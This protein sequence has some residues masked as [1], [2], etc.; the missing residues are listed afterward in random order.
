MKNNL[1]L[2]CASLLLA[3]P[4][5]H[6][7]N[8]YD[9]GHDY[10]PITTNF[11]DAEGNIV[12]SNSQPSI[13]TP[14]NIYRAEIKQAL[15]NETKRLQEAIRPWSDRVGRWLE[16]ELESDDQEARGQ[17]RNVVPSAG[18]MHKLVKSARASEY[19]MSLMLAQGP[20]DGS[21][22][23]LT[24]EG[25]PQLYTYLEKRA[26][27]FGIPMP[28][29]VMPIHCEAR[30]SILSVPSKH[31]IISLNPFNLREAGG[32]H[33]EM[34]LDY[35]MIGVK[36]N[37]VN[38]KWWLETATRY[39]PLAIGLIAGLKG[40]GTSGG[41][42]AAYG[43][44]A[45]GVTQA[46]MYALSGMAQRRMINNDVSDVIKY[47]PS[48]ARDLLHFADHAQKANDVLLG[49]EKGYVPMKDVVVGNHPLRK[50]QT[51]LYD[52]GYQARGALAD[53][54]NAVGG[55]WH[56]AQTPMVTKGTKEEGWVHTS[57]RPGLHDIRT[58]RDAGVAIDNHL[59]KDWANGKDGSLQV[60][61]FA[62]MVDDIVTKA[63]GEQD[64]VDVAEKEAATV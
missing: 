46:L 52:R 44:G 41:R 4:V 53:G 55:N 21:F 23:A 57:L 20:F 45:F 14:E 15:E 1:L 29:V 43:T 62:Q 19:Q 32:K 6:A 50:L 33:L 40:A 27:D 51:Y 42:A 10:T 9:E 17:G 56:P 22:V 37:N 5:A 11:L 47:D 49:D 38:K 64:A 26:A 12:G 61:D 60:K 36:N 18:L 63:E 39:V 3:S 58:A 25:A 28:L 24:R 16:S 54:V 35:L 48:R 59:V 7:T 2:L 30:F 31:S 13:K 34:Y 8:P